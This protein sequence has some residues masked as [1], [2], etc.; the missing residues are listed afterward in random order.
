MFVQNVEQ[1]VRDVIKTPI[2]LIPFGYVSAAEKN[3]MENVVF[4]EEK[5][6]ELEPLV[7]L[8]LGKS[9]T[10]ALSR[11]LAPFVVNIYKQ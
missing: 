11:I 10:H 6:Q 9:A 3:S 7:P 1:L 4:A 5:E 8:E 2:H